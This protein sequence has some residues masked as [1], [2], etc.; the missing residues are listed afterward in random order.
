MLSYLE[1]NEFVG[2]CPVASEDQLYPLL[3]QAFWQAGRSVVGIED[4]RGLIAFLGLKQ[5]DQLFHQSTSG[6]PK[7]VFAILF[8]VHDDALKH[9]IVAVDQQTHG[10]EVFSL[11][12]G[13]VEVHTGST[14]PIR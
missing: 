1:L 8:R 7:S 4:D 9:Q 6:N 3:A 5:R 2:R 11:R 12:L 14:R 13:C 10:N